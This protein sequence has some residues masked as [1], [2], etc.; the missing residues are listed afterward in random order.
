MV[1]NAA[2]MCSM[3]QPPSGP[4]SLKIGDLRGRGGDH[5]HVVG[6][7]QGRALWSILMSIRSHIELPS[8][9]KFIR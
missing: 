8:I 1:N 3:F 5:R 2:M 9:F 6:K 4:L 7:G